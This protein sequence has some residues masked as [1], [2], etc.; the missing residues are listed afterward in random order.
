MS[1]QM[2]VAEHVVG[3]LGLRCPICNSK[4]IEYLGPPWFPVSPKDGRVTLRHMLQYEVACCKCDA[5]W[6]N[7]Y[8]I[9]FAELMEDEDDSE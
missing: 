8:T 2:H 4:S 3:S 1:N 9:S 6:Q 5:V 7:T